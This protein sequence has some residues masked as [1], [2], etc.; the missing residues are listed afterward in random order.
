MLSVLPFLWMYAIFLALKT[1]PDK[2]LFKGALSISLI[3]LLSAVVMDYIFFGLIRNAMEELYHPT[4][5]Y[6]YAFLLVLPF[7][8]G[9]IFKKRIM[10]IRIEASKSMAV[11]AAA[12][13][14]VCIAIL[15]LIIVK[16]I[17]L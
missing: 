13:G 12:I 14:F 7:I 11:K 10:R 4:T 15:T 16:D 17:E 6:G 2:H 8:V 9:L 3:L 5:L 1:F